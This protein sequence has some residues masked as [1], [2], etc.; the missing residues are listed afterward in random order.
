MSQGAVLS[1]NTLQ[2]Y[3]TKTLRESAV[4]IVSV[5]HNLFATLD[6]PSKT[7]TNTHNQYQYQSNKIYFLGTSRYSPKPI[8]FSFIVSSRLI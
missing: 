2:T 1:S 8:S 5:S 7:E 4:G 6:T 3:V